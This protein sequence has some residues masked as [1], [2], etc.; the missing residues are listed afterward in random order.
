MNTPVV[1]AT[2][3]Q[4]PVCGGQLTEVFLCTQV[5]QECQCCGW[6]VTWAPSQDGGDQ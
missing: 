3:D 2:D 4:C 6:S 1:W 5:I